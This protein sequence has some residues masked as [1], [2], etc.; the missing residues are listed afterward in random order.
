MSIVLLECTALYID[1]GFFM[2]NQNYNSQ[3]PRFRW[4]IFSSR[5]PYSL[6][7]SQICW[8]LPPMGFVLKRRTGS[9]CLFQLITTARRKCF[10]F[11]DFFHNCQIMEE[12]SMAEQLFPFRKTRLWQANSPWSTATWP[13]QRRLHCIKKY[14]GFGA[15][16]N[17]FEPP[18]N[19]MSPPSLLHFEKMVDVFQPRSRSVL[20]LLDQSISDSTALMSMSQRAKTVQKLQETIYSRIDG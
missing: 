10:M 19:G 20:F 2:I 15:F 9:P 13:K 16:F 5:S 12:R 17:M 6:L 14:L 3:H 11:G 7:F 1:M 18:T 4:E 8:T